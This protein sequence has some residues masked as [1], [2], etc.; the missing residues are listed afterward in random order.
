MAH[1]ETPRRLVHFGMGGLAFALPYLTPVQAACAAGAAVVFNLFLLP[2][3][4]P[5]LFRRG[6]RD[7]PW[8]SGVVIYP[9]TVLLLVLLFRRHMEI[10][11]AAWAILAAGDSAAGFIGGRLGRTP[12]PWNR[13]KTAEGSGAFAVAAFVFSWA[14]LVW[15]GRRPLE[16]AFL[17]S[18][19]SLFAAFMESLPWRLDDNFTVPILSAIFLAGLVRVDLERLVRAAPELWRSLLLGATINLILAILFRRSG[20]V[21]RSGMIAGFLVGVLTFTFASWQGFLVLIAFF[22]LGSA[23]TRLGLRRKQR[24]GIAQEKKGARSA[25]HALANCGV[26]VYLAFLVAAASSPEVFRLALVC[27]Y[28]TAAFD[29]VSSEIGRAY[30]GRPVLITTL[31]RVPAGTNGAVS[32]LGTLA[33]IAASAAVCG[34]AVAAGFLEGRFSGVVLVAAFIGS[35]ADSVLGATLES[36]GFIDN[37]AV[38]F[39]NTLVGSLSGIGLLVLL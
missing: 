1:G 22:V 8:R 27:A 21:D 23:S 36:R 29:T 6:E 20:A 33:G 12:I 34:V 18:A 5:S 14:V 17:A 16:A 25:R 9:V 31:R 11:G 37:E 3:V 38:N 39:S 32:W 2:R 10:A 26:A 24:L 35:T 30:G 4:G 15:M 7:S 13:S 28:A 19:T